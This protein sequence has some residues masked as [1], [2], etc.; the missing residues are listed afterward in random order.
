[1]RLRFHVLKTV[2]LM[3]CLC[4]LA[5]PASTGEWREV[6]PATS[7]GARYGHAMTTV[8]GVPYLF[9]GLDKNTSMVLDDFWK[10]DRENETWVEITRNQGD[11]WP[12]ARFYHNMVT[13]GDRILVANGYGLPPDEPNYWLFD[14]STGQWTEPGLATYPPAR[15]L[16][17]MAALGEGRVFVGGGYP[18]DGSESLNDAWILSFS[19]SGKT[20]MISTMQ[21][22]PMPS[23]NYGF[24]AAAAY[25]NPLVIGGYIP[26]KCGG[27]VSSDIFIFNFVTGSWEVVAVT[28]D[29]P[30]GRGLGAA[31]YWQNLSKTPNW[32]DVVIF[33]GGE[34]SEKALA[35][36][37]VQLLDTT[38]EVWS[39]LDDLPTALS[40][41]AAAALPPKEGDA[42][43]MF[44]L[45]TF[46]GL[47][48][49]GNTN[50]RTWIYT[51]DLYVG[52][53]EERTVFIPAA[54]HVDGA[55][56]SVWR[57]DVEVMNRGTR[58]AAVTLSLLKRDQ[59]NPDPETSGPYT[60]A[61]GR[62]LRFSDLVDDLF[63][64]SGAA[65]LK[66][67]LDSSDVLVTS[68]TYNLTADG[69]YGQFIE[70]RDEDSA[71]DI[72]HPAYMIQLASSENP[73]NGFRSNVGIVNLSGETAGF[74]IE[75]FG[76][77]GISLGHIPLE[78]EAWEYVQKSRV[79]AA[80][81]AG[82]LTDG[83]AVV[84][85]TGES[86]RFLAY[87]SVIDNR[88]NDPTYISAR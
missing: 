27:T 67:D 60:I 70:G 45:L 62:S 34:S 72:D 43:N 30:I 6:H 66:L 18:V 21:L 5:A 24:S 35:T 59:S 49:D 44:E 55:Q 19:G 80:V 88:T 4:G 64:F 65:A 7:P 39:Y 9:G 86:T 50:Q 79:F 52:P 3:S 57:S 10:W 22:P 33:I 82:E 13:V 20:A 84:R 37:T 75:L 47:D 51:S 85:T 38:T 2:V 71:F 58:S 83:F 14:P 53:K 87:A 17:G 12:A 63:S 15:A 32:G 73:G 56:G 78:L 61:A 25:G 69:T 16:G 41:L 29:T 74:D 36:P 76:A 54:A 42:D 8:G 23:A 31:V 46:G 81:G 68:R 77:D 48:I 1:M 26:E 11:S 40:S 28:G